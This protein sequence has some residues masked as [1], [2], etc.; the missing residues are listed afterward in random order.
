M[1]VYKAKSLSD[2][3][4]LLEKYKEKKAKVINGGTDLVISIRNK[5]ITPDVLIDVSDIKELKEIR[6]DNEYLYLGAGVTFTEIIENDLFNG[7]LSGFK[8]ACSLIGSPQIRNR[9]T[10]GGN[11]MNAS[12]AADSVPPLL[13]LDSM[14]VF[15][16][17][18]GKREISLS[19]FYKGKGRLPIR[20]NELLTAIYF[21]KPKNSLGFVKLGAR[22]AMTIS[23]VS[24]ASIIEVG[25][26]SRIKNLKLASGALARRPLREEEVE[27]FFIG[28][29]FDDTVIEE[30]AYILQ[31]Q[32]EKRLMEEPEEIRNRE[33]VFLP[34]KK[35]AI[36]KLLREV[37][38]E[39]VGGKS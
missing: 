36:L 21:K 1:L 11:I 33:M 8:K 29:P 4:E 35:R 15:E 7:F 31:Q 27:K 20:N 14:L 28:K 32:V 39:S 3:L 26:D 30:G 13:C 5:K 25:E 24:L 17:V 22:K 6:T 18:D 23:K 34:Y 10:V 38:Y 19:D 2:A 37:L 12:P 16:S 9:G